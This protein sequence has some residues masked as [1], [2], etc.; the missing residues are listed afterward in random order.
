MSSNKMQ[1]HILYKLQ[2]F[3]HNVKTNVKFQ[4]F[5]VNTI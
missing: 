2:I 5:D 3:Q 1:I 4:D